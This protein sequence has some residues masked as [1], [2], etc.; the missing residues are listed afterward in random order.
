M[1]QTLSLPASRNSIWRSFKTATWLG[2]KIE[3]NWTDPFLF[4]IYSVIKPLAGAGILVVM[5]SIISQGNLGKPLFAY[6]F[7]GNAFFQF[8]AS[9]MTGVSWAIIDDR[10]D[11]RT[12]KYLYTAP[13]SMPWY[14]MG[15]A[16]ARIIIAVFS[17]IL[18]LAVGFI[19]LQVPFNPAIIDWPLLLVTLVVGI[20]MLAMIG[21]LLAGASLAMAQ[22]A[23]GL[24]DTVAGALFIFSGAI[25]PISQLP[26][27][28]QPLGYMMPISYWL[29]LVRRAMIGNVAE[30]FPTFST[31][32]NSQL[33]LIL[34]GLTVVFTVIGILGWRWCDHNARERGLI[35]QTQNY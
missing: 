9:V 13:L 5:Y 6:I 22:H 18:T 35:D 2:W 8:V 33:M 24:G 29:E 25:Y 23:F 31:L 20:F 10:E 1:N 15:R 28:L 17:V 34:L 32:S 16:I 30:A 7:I 14:L 19:F 3:S 27:W 11:Y 12:L 21:L 4:F 26:V